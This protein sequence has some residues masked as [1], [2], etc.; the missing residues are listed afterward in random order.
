VASALHNTTMDNSCDTF[1]LILNT[2]D[3]R[4]DDMM[5]T[6]ASSKVFEK[7]D[8]ERL[9]QE[10]H[11]AKDF[12]ISSNLEGDQCGHR[13]CARTHSVL[14]V[15]Y[16]I[17]K[18]ED[19]QTTDVFD[20]LCCVRCKNDDSAKVIRHVFAPCIIRLARSRKFFCECGKRLYNKF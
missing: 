2:S 17:W 14:I 18:A 1:A 7:A 13:Q 16:S 20:N 5:E 8:F 11:G 10:V 19:C 6:F 12:V 15:A 4:R 9:F 3:E